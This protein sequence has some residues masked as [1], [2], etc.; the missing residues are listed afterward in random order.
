MKNRLF[1]SAIITA[2][3]FLFCIPCES[4]TPI[5]TEEAEKDYINRKEAFAQ[6]PGWKFRCK[7]MAEAKT[8]EDYGGRIE[9][10]KKMDKLLADA[11]KFFQVPGIN[12]AGNNQ[13]HFFMTDMHEFT[14]QS[15]PFMLMDNG[16][17]DTTC[18]LRI[19]V[20]GNKTEGDMSGGW[21]GNPYLNLG[22]DF[23]GLFL[24]YAINALVHEFG[25][26]RGVPDL[27]SAELTGENN[28]ING[29]G[30]EATRCIMN[31]PYG[32]NVWS[33][34][35]KMIINVSADTR[36][37]TMHYTF[38]AKNGSQAK[39]L[40]AN[41]ETALGAY[42]KF[43]PVYAYSG[44]VADQPLYEG[45]ISEENGYVFPQDPF[46]VPNQDNKDNNITNYLVEITYNGKTTYR[47]MPMYEA[48]YA[49]YNGQDPYIFTIRLE[50]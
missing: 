31:Y 23:E 40:K 43:Y 32:E 38:L 44:K 34:Y 21:M 41:G 29:E 28:P 17:T 46:I 7:V 8:I 26:V 9:F 4:D 47:W 48:Q 6:L 50:E 42:L 30:F 2:I 49:A 20:N 18:D 39:V 22:H 36:L 16:A 33:D 5:R 25:H 37:C 3:L 45:E 12:D 10:M 11:S 1:H 24:G 19:I 27:Y 13:I 14:G 35:A 15:K